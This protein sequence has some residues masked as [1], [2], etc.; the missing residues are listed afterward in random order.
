M[1]DGRV[2]VVLE[3]A[4]GQRVRL[5]L[6]AAPAAPGQARS[7]AVLHTASSCCPTQRVQ[8]TWALAQR[9]APKGPVGQSVACGNKSRPVARAERFGA[10]QAPESPGSVRPSAPARRAPGFTAGAYFIGKALW[11]KGYTELLAL[12]A[13]HKAASGVALRVDAYGA[14]EDAEDIRAKARAAAVPV[15][16]LWWATGGQLSCRRH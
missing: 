11:G 15:F 13:A 7:Q 10:P 2:R 5:Q 4:D 16:T 14:G 9:Q 1:G 12:L 3:A 6:L 8:D